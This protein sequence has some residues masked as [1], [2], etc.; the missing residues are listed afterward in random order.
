MNMNNLKEADKIKIELFKYLQKNY[1]Q[2]YLA[3]PEVSIG[4]AVIDMLL[5]NGEIHIFEI[6]SKT[7]SLTRL[8]KQINSYKKHADKITVVAD[9]RFEQK[10]KT[11]SFMQGIGLIIIDETYKFQEIQTSEKFEISKESYFSYWS[12]IEMRETLRGF[13]QWY[14]YTTSDAY[15]KL[16]EVLDTKQTRRLTIHRI[17]Q[18][19]HDEYL[20]RK[21]AIQKE[22]YESFLKARFSEELNSLDITPL[23]ELPCRVMFDFYS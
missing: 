19:Y 8:E 18:K 4:K 7:D 20:K 9:K 23:L 17:K 14:K 13:P 3:L 21:Q 12:P 11:L 2:D 6:K 5:V 15:M 22:D 1:K 16:L 10:I